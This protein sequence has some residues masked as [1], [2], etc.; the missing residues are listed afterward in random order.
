MASINDQWVG[1]G[2]TV[3]GYEI[4]VITRDSVEVEKDGVRYE[5]DV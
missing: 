5:L 2:D 3:T 1:V 4:V